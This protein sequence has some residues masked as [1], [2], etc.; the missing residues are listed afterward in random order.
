MKYYRITAYTPYCGEH[1]TDYIA[2]DD[3]EELKEFVQCIIDD[4]AA[5]WE[6]GWADY[7]EEGYES[8]EEWQEDYY[9]GCGATV[10]EISEAE[11][12][13]E[14]KPRWPFELVKEGPGWEGK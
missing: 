11:Y 2:T 14:T 7:A 5:E 1:M 10:Q 6:P 8:E 13:E 4:N 3:E 9:A 12:K